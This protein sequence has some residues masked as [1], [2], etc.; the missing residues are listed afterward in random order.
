M[1]EWTNEE[2]EELRSVHDEAE[3]ATTSQGAELTSLECQRL[4]SV[5]VASC[6][7]ELVAA[8]GGVLSAHVL[9]G[10]RTA[11]ERDDERWGNDRMR[12]ALEHIIV[13]G[14]R[15][16]ALEQERDV[17]LAMLKE[18]EVML[19]GFRERQET[20]R[21]AVTRLEA[22]NAECHRGA[23][24]MRGHVAALKTELDAIRPGAER[25]MKM[26]M[27]TGRSVGGILDDAERFA[28]LKPS[29]RVAEDVERVREALLMRTGPVQIP[30]IADEAL[31]RLASGAQRAEHERALRYTRQ[32]D[33]DSAHAAKAVLERE[34]DALRGMLRRVEAELGAGAGAADVRIKAL[35][36]RVEDLEK[37]RWDI[38]ERLKAVGE[39]RDVAKD[40]AERL[41]RRVD[42]LTAEC[43][44]RLERAESAESRIAAIR[45][46][47]LHPQSEDDVANIPERV[48]QIL[49]GDAPNHS[50]P[51]KSSPNSPGIPDGSSG[52]QEDVVGVCGSCGGSHPFRRF[53]DMWRCSNCGDGFT[54][55]PCSPICPH[56][57][58]ATPGHLERVKAQSEAA[59]VASGLSLYG[60]RVEWEAAFEQGVEAMRAALLRE[61][62]EACDQHGVDWL[63]QHLKHRFD[64]ATP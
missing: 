46:L 45:E 22:E 15:I 48:R 31:S 13:Q 40:E 26:A 30:D 28:S 10:M 29:G 62:K 44:R 42:G 61:A 3:V 17:A 34:V 60:K 51:L 57:D 5:A 7:V 21:G 58:A 52:R 20:L 24:E 59:N 8:R 50:V 47:A 19:S 64:G 43:N 18:R 12:D 63:Y 11:A 49:D 6:A 32:A 39:A 2:Q 27:A 35:R 9:A 14:A 1:I 38:G 33:A 16:A 37:S 36:A 53:G 41:K 25:L 56:A 4:T 54:T 23:E 55:F